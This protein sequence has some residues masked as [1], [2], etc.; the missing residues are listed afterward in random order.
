MI[1]TAKASRILVADD[2]P[3]L[4]MGIVAL[5]A[6]E[7]DMQVVGEAS[8]GHEAIAQFRLLRPDITLLDIQM[9]EMDGMDAL[10]AIRGEYPSA[11]IIVFTTYGGDVL[12]RRALEAG[13]QAYVL[14]G[15]IREELVDIIRAVLN[16]LR[17]VSSDV[18][19]QLAY[20]MGDDQLSERE[21]DVLRLM[22]EGNSNR[23]IA[24]ALAI[25]EATAKSHVQS[26]L[27]KLQARDRSHAVALALKRG[28]IRLSVP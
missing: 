5:V 23:R 10:I 8:T 11:R 22:S 14:K 4:R 9:P 20:H 19:Q 1:A 27:G 17:R 26:I 25:S 16:G 28:I 3:V 15:M 21:L 12:A 6:N 7:A 13:A 24:Q 2:H 18:A